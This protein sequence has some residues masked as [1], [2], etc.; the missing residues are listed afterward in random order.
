M[1]FLVFVLLLLTAS[2]TKSETYK[3]QDITDVLEGLLVGSFGDIGHQAK[4]CMKDGTDVYV[5]FTSAVMAF[6][7]RDVVGVLGGIKAL[8]DVIDLIPDEVEN[9]ESLSEL[10]KDFSDIAQEFRN[11][12]DISIQIDSEIRWRGVS[13]FDDIFNSVEHYFQSDFELSGEDI[14]DIIKSVFLDKSIQNNKND[15]IKDIEDFLEGFFKGALE[16]DSVDVNDCIEDAYDLYEELLTVIEDLEDEGFLD[17][18]HILLDLI[19][20][21]TDAVRSVAQCEKIGPEAKI[22]EEWVIEMENIEEMEYK[23]FHAF[24][25]FPQRIK[26]DIQNSIDGYRSKDYLTSGFSLGDLLH[27][28]F[29]EVEIE[30]V[31]ELM[32]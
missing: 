13:V 18:E 27:I 3:D 5:G 6:A 15:E 19:D 32:K 28:L 20:L 10:V 8:G 31:S 1:K 16:K 4:D 24:L 9:C 17:I 2:F 22:L 21:I 29:V 14:G 25:E 11:P 30:P 26:D 23:V 12:K 7:S